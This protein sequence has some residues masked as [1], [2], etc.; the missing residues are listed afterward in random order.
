[1]VVWPSLH[2]DWCFKVQAISDKGWAWSVLLEVWNKIN[3]FFKK[4]DSSLFR[5]MFKYNCLV[6]NIVQILRYRKQPR[7]DSSNNYQ[8]GKSLDKI[9]VLSPT[10]ELL[11]PTFLHCQHIP[12]NFRSPN[13]ATHLQTFRKSSIVFWKFATIFPGDHYLQC[14]YGCPY[15]QTR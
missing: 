7:S 3:D 15:A 1:M 10:G 4:I 5:K 9:L 8:G 13:T 6:E 12:P 14:F 11:P 2:F